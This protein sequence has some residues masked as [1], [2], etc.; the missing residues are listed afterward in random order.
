VRAP[1]PTATVRPTGTA[2]VLRPTFR[3]FLAAVCG[4]LIATAALVA[5]FGVAAAAGAPT[6]A[7]SPTFD[8]HQKTATLAA[9]V[10]PNG[11]PLTDCHFVWGTGAPAGRDVSCESL[12]A[13]ASNSNLAIAKVS[14]LS[15]GTEYQYKL[16]AAN[17]AGVEGGP[18]QSFTTTRPAASQS[19]INEAIRERQRATALPACR[20]YE[21]AS[22]VEKNG[23]DVVG[24]GITNVAAADGEAIAFNSR[25]SFGDTIGSGVS[26]QTQYLARRGEAG[27]RTHAIDPTPN[28]EALQTSFDYSAIP[29]FSEDLD[30]ALLWAYDL[31]SVEGDIPQRKNIYLEDPT[32]RFL[33]PVTTLHTETTVSPFE[34]LGPGWASEDVSGLSAD[35]EHVLLTSRAQ[36]LPE[37]APGFKNTYEWSRSG[38]RLIDQLPDGSLPSEGAVGVDSGRHELS[39]DGMSRDGSRSLFFAPEYGNQQLYMHIDGAATVGIT[40][41]QGGASPPEPEGVSFQAMTPDGRNVFFT[42]T[43]QLLPE[44]HNS[45]P[46]LYRWTDSDDPVHHGV[47]TQITN[48]GEFTLDG[49]KNGVVGVSD[50]GT[51]VYYETLSGELVLWDNGT[52]RLISSDALENSGEENS[53]AAVASRPG[54]GRVSPDGNWL[55]FLS[56][57]TLGAHGISGLTGQIIENAST[58]EGHYEMYLYDLGDN[59]LTCVSCIPRSTADASITP[60][61]TKGDPHL[62]FADIRPHF[63]ADNGTVFFSTSEALS[64][65]DVNGIADTYQYDPAVGRPELLSA[66]RAAAPAMFVDANPS[67]HDVFMVSR[68]RLVGRDTDDLVDVYDARSGG[69]FSEP[70]PSAPC[71]GEACKPPPS[72]PPATPAAFSTAA[73]PGNT[74][75]PRRHRRHH[76]RHRRDKSDRRNA[77][78]HGRGVK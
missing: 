49:I 55:A 67:G 19:C 22:P 18:V 71:L 43:S 35:A 21:M 57:S 38:L 45:G 7:E 42:T 46:D 59:A 10:N 11:E 41:P 16:I 15:P 73:G 78:H 14:A 65:T 48:A 54:F 2:R 64:S 77:N 28:P 27:W 36:L 76:H 6:I 1:A 52:T 20:A 17:A 29:F 62:D 53:L 56:N 4:S 75:H 34:F 51:R 25:T 72:V 44:D 33:T 39:R 74:M 32:T 31:P 47:L 58:S 24:D 68:Q 40:E 8:L 70:P 69:G 3:F 50:D 13:S 26:G 30:R 12:F 61:V 63:L 60:A 23:G 37:A 66:G 5:A 9:Y